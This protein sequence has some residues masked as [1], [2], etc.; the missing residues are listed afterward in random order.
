MTDKPDCLPCE[1]KRLRKRV[2]SLLQANNREVERRRAAEARVREL[3]NPTPKRKKLLILGFA[4]HGKDTV[5][6]I[7]RDQHG[8]SFRSSS[9]FLAELVC[10]P[11]LAERGVTY[12]SLEAC[13]EDRVNYR[14]EW[15]D[16]IATWNAEDPALLSK[17]ILK[18]ADIYVGMRSIRE[19]EAAKQLYDDVWWV[20][21]TD[22]GLP[23]EDQSSMNLMFIPGEMRRIDNNGTLE[24][25][26]RTVN[27]ALKELG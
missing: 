24:D 18:V 12:D 16:A 17:E 27:E 13:Y 11:Y 7:L 19:Y 25:L 15:H 26:R 23:P 4:R 14:A 20:D 8:F 10:R 6:E 5:A 3:E 2:D 9:Y 1:I 22:R 21:A